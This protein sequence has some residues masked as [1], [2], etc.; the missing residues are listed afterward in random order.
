MDTKF[1]DG[2][3]MKANTSA[4][5]EVPFTGSPQPSVTWNYNGGPL[6][7]IR[8][9]FSE[10]IYNMTALTINRAKLSDAGDYR[11]TLENNNGKTSITIK[12]K[13]IGKYH[14]INPV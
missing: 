7:D 9:T 6:P 3:T 10:T 14:K 5:I 2:M 8:R 11:L 13:V 4:I 1:K 12:V